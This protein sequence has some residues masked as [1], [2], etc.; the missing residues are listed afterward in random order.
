M[1][2]G[3]PQQSGQERIAGRADVQVD[4][5]AFELAGRVVEGF[6]ITVDARPASRTEISGTA[7]ETTRYQHEIIANNAAQKQVQNAMRWKNNELM[8]L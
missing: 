2:S 3:K 4:Y 5:F 1:C 6:R 8:G 7:A